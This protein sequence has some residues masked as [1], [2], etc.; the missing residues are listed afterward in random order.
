MHTKGYIKMPRS[1][2]TLPLT[3]RVM[4]MHLCAECQYCDAEH[5]VVGTL[6][7][8]EIVTSRNALSTLLDL[9]IQSVRTALAWLESNGYI[10]VET[11]AR[12]T[13]I[14]VL[15]QDF[16]ALNGFEIMLNNQVNNQV[17][18]QASNQVLTSASVENTSS[19]EDEKILPT[20]SVTKPLTKL[21]TNNNIKY[22]ENIIT[23]TSNSK[24]L[25][26]TKNAPARETH[27]HTRDTHEQV[28]ELALFIAQK[29]PQFEAMKYPF[30]VE[31][32]T[33]IVEENSLDDAQTIL[34]EAWANEA[35]LGRTTSARVV[36]D[37]YARGY[38]AFLHRYRPQATPTENSRLLTYSEMLNEFNKIG[39]GTTD[40]HFVV[41]D[42][43]GADGEKR[44][45]RVS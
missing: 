9:S 41:A 6:H 11:T 4:M 2:N 39:Y 22:I 42:V 1:I 10:K 20:K 16:L 28:Q 14:T 18:N 24:Y 26:E 29:T 12:Y 23:H 13:K 3:S 5:P 25:V 34:R 45:V 37:K 31:D 27:A 17:N 15:W 35:Y 8:G 21:A 40:D 43:L 32:L 44:W 19:C 36:F 7:V 30:T 33:E 38:Y